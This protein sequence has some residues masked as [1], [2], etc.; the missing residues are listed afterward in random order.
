[1]E[2]VTRTA[3]ILLALSVPAWAGSYVGTITLRRDSDNYAQGFS[4]EDRGGLYEV[5][6]ADQWCATTA[7]G[8]CHVVQWKPFG[9]PAVIQPIAD[10]QPLYP[11]FMIQFRHLV[12][13][14]GDPAQY[15]LVQSPPV[16]MEVRA[17]AGPELQTQLDRIEQMLRVICEQDHLTTACAKEPKP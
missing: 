7:G 16:D 6:G 3:L 1:M 9:E 13:P 15:N 8:P 2:A 10:S 17:F 14:I 12:L 5:P 4:V 11:D